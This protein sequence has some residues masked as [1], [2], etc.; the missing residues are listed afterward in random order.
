MVRLLKMQKNKPAILLP[1]DR[2]TG[3][4]KTGSITALITSGD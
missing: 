2:R 4:K 1:K 3:N